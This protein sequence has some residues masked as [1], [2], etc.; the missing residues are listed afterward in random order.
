MQ[1][2]KE[3]VKK[4]AVWSIKVKLFQI[5]LLILKL[6]FVSC[7]LHLICFILNELLP[8]CCQTATL[9]TK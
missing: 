7:D 2:A 5:P 6:I 9:T 3:G 1:I 8:E 4:L